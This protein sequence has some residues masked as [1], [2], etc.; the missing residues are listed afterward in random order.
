MFKYKSTITKYFSTSTGK[1]LSKT[2]E[3]RLNS[4]WVESSSPEITKVM[5]FLHGLFGNSNN[6]RRISNSPII[7]DRRRSLLIDL[8]NHGDSEHSE[9][10][11]YSEMADD[12]IRHMDSLKIEKFT[13]LGHSMGGKVAMNLSLRYSDRLDGLV[14]VDS[15]PKDHKDNPN[16]YGG[17]KHIIDYVEQMEVEGRTRKEVLEELKSKFQGSVANLMNTN[18]IYISPES[19]KVTWR[20]N[21][22]AIRNNYDKIID[23][24]P[25]SNLHYTGPIKV[26]VGEKSYIFPID[27]YQKV[28]PKLHE[29]DFSVVPGAGHWVHADKPNEVTESIAHFLDKI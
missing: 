29:K 8:R 1:K 19:D 20:C 21:V 14:V 23:F 25:E 24:E 27:I 5:V 4:S 26:I 18:L 16:I 3:V 15:A 11:G 7:R 13:L 22:K 9:S 2:G 6:W 17:T 10:M 12:V 28:F